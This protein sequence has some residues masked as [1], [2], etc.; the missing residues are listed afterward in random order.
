MEGGSKG[1]HP[2]HAAGA[3]WSRQ[4]PS[5]RPHLLH[6]LLGGR[7][8]LP[9]RRLLLQLARQHLLLGLQHRGALGEGQ[10]R[11]RGRAQNREGGRGGRSG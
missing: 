11:L 1:R 9:R 3:L 8:R 2:H 5:S 4:A 6:L 7:T 10:Q